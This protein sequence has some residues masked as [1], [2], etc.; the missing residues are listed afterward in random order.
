MDRRVSE[1]FLEAIG[2]EAFG[3]GELIDDQRRT[4]ES[5]RQRLPKI[6]KESGRI[7]ECGVVVVNE[8]VIGELS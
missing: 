7:Q 5:Q 3:D 6:R 1:G 8:E 4:G 2:R